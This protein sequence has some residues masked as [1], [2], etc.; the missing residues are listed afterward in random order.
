[1]HLICS[2]VVPERDPALPN[3]FFTDLPT[4]GTVVSKSAFVYSS[5]FVSVHSFLTSHLICTSRE[6]K[7]HRIPREEIGETS[8]NSVID[9]E[10]HLQANCLYILMG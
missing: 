8:D 2:T 6:V 3:F 4:K 7:L 1:M 10:Q 5:T 9:I